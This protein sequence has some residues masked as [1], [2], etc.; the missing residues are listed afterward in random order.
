MRDRHESA[1]TLPSDPAHS[2]NIRQFSKNGRLAAV[3]DW[4]SLAASNIQ[5]A[6]RCFITPECNSQPR[7]TDG[8]KTHREYR[9]ARGRFGSSADVGAPL[10]DVRRHI[11]SGHFPAVR[12]G[13]LVPSTATQVQ[14]LNKLSTTSSINLPMLRKRRHQRLH[15][16]C[17]QRSTAASKY[18]RAAPRPLRPDAN[19][20]LNV[21]RRSPRADVASA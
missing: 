15:C 11:D 2:R 20:L 19:A 18:R 10:N 14:T 12:P 5:F 13:R 8:S 6:V 21:G 17:I 1:M 4:R 16:E 7:I 9:R 3:Q